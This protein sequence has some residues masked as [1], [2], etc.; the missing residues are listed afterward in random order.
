MANKGSD[1][2][3][4][5]RRGVP[6][7]ARDRLSAAEARIDEVRIA[8]ER[9][10][11]ELASQHAELLASLT[12]R[13]AETDAQFEAL[14]AQAKED[15][16]RQVGVLDVV[17][18]QQKRQDE[19]FGPRVE[20]VESAVAA[21]AV[22]QAAR[23]AQGEVRVDQLEVAARVAAGR[24]DAFEA[25]RVDLGTIVE[26]MNTTIRAIRDAVEKL[27][28]RTDALDALSRQQL[29]DAAATRETALTAERAIG[30]VA[31]QA[32]AAL[33]TLND[34]DQRLSAVAGTVAPLGPLPDRVRALD[35]SVATM[36][37]RVTAAELL[38]NQRA[39]LDLQLER[40]EEFERLLAEV[41][42]ATYA[43]RD[44]VDALRELIHQIAENRSL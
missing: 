22:E 25:F 3:R 8:Q 5:L 14:R 40:A 18:R 13:V 1:R 23:L 24:I 17:R 27:S 31:A 43:S 10:S 11:V 36:N 19:T 37:D 9:M 34:L 29:A 41:D 16:R 21:L 33:S 7:D 35:E 26:R 32:Q 20:A 38:V 6:S 15:Y 30:A 39:N 42:P 28:T 44:D 12:E 4:W 2:K